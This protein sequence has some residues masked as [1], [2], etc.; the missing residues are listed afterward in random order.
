MKLIFLICLLFL[1]SCSGER[2]LNL[3]AQDDLLLLKC[4]DKPNCVQS[5][6]PD[7]E[8]HFIKPIKIVSNKE[9]AH[10]KIVG[11]LSKDSSAK[12]IK[13]DE[14]YIYA[15]F[16]SS[17]FQFVDD[18][19]FFFT[20]DLIHFRSASR[21]GHSDLGANKKRIEKI[22]FKFHQNDY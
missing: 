22:K 21:L 9:H 19:E 12:I 3:G 1:V 6:R 17:I 5:Q 8:D 7:D 11:I 13:K 20:E 15:E 14:N 16:T 18:V 10:K 4:P 2:P